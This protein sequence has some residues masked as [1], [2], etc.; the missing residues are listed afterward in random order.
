MKK[1]LLF[2][3]LTAVLGL[4]ACAGVQKDDSAMQTAE[5]KM[6]TA[7]NWTLE[8]VTIPAGGERPETL[9]QQVRPFDL[10]FM[11]NRL[12]VSGLCNSMSGSYQ[13]A[14]D[15]I[16]VQPMMGTKM[17]CADEAVMQSEN[18]VGQVL[19]TVQQWQLQGVDMADPAQAH[20]VLTLS[21]ADG[22]RWQFEG[23]PTPETLYGQEGT[24]AFL[25][26][27]DQLQTCGAQNE[28]CY[29]VRSV[30]YN[31]QGIQT[32][33]GD[34]FLLDRDQLQGFTPEAGYQTIIRTR[35]FVEKTTQGKDRPVYIHDMTVESKQ[36]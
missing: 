19:P 20:P 18:Y 30:K 33:V 25:E 7:Y 24:T 23:T 4:S 2:I 8:R 16:Q 31:E 15:K 22:A 14:Q 36:L 28:Q 9:G 6:L 21:F 27:S 11:D 3:S 35:Q 32:E 10:S 26:V 29:K 5:Q 13:I 17:M 12:A 34:W 1:T